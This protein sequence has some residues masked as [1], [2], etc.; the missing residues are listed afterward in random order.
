[1]IN[2]DKLKQL[3]ENYKKSFSTHWKDEKFKWEAV[4]HFQEHWNI[5][6]ENFG[7]MFK[8][9][10]A[11][12]A[13][14]LTSKMFYP[15]GMI[16]DFAKAND[17]STRQ[18]FRSL[19]NENQD[20]PERI[21]AFRNSAEEIRLKYGADTWQKH[22]Q[23]I[24]AIS[25]YLWLM[26]PDKYYIYKH[27][28]HHCVAKTLESNINLKKR[29]SAQTVI[30]AYK[31]CDEI[32]GAI[33]EDKELL[34]MLHHALDADCYADPSYKT[35]TIDVCYYIQQ[36]TH[37][38]ESWFPT[39]YHPGLT[40]KNWLELLN[41]PS[42]FHDYDLKIMKRMKDYGGQATCKQLSVKYGCHANF[43]NRGSSSLAERIAKKTNC[44][45]MTTDTDNSKWW[46]ILYLGQY[47][48]N[49]Q[50]GGY[51]W[52]LRD[53]LAEALNQVDLS[54][55]PLYENNAT[56]SGLNYW[57]LT[58][59]PNIWSFSDMKVGEEQT[60]T[61]Y[62]EEGNKRKVF[63][64]FLDVRVGDI[65][66]GYEATPKKEIVAIAEITQESNEETI[67]F[68]IKE[69]LTSPIPYAEIIASSE[70]QNMEFLKI[71]YGSLFKLSKGEYDF[72]MDLIRDKNPIIQADP[73]LIKYTKA[74]F[75]KEVY[76]AEE[77]Y[78][79]LTALL[80]YKYNVI[81]QGAPGVGKTFSA[82]RLAYSIMGEIDDSRIELIQFHQNYSYEDFIMGYR[83]DGEGF[84]LTEGIFYRFCHKAAEHPDKPYFFII[85]EINRGNMS[86]IFGELL[87]LIEK[88][89]RNTQSTL[90]Y[91]GMPFFVPKNIR[92]IGMMN[93]ADRSLSL[94]DYALRRRFSFFEIEPGF[95]TQGF[96]AYQNGFSNEIFNKLI[97]Q[98]KLLNKEIEHDNSLGKGFQI[99]HSY[100]C[101]RKEDECTLPW[102]NAIVEFDILPML[103][104][105]WFDEPDKLKEWAEK[106]RSV[107]H[108]AE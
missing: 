106:L 18:I 21:E 99:G 68:K 3:L 58:A 15:R 8:E 85:D 44:P 54:T 55:I 63:Q 5:D 41:D 62:N 6:A 42:V 87:M 1:M 49:K 13:N 65:V 100:F 11:K 31:L 64:N 9:A 32:C 40:V 17:D 84:K 25:T 16:L 104:E 59:K 43:Y 79:D 28:L 35:A 39:H 60:Y 47:T 83:P 53:E 95:N 23:T 81:L 51:K 93:T 52:K 90:A 70:L 73:A 74:D 89:Y 46:P 61:L 101:G 57:W 103:A 38:T 20:L 82:K 37:P 75:L 36:S 14:L 72:I 29:G 67:A 98:I 94:I 105:Y 86:K 26:Y 34:T 88:D 45:V 19:F 78:N 96:M 27:D 33:K 24:N 7:E 108:E 12:T 91:N 10:T 22:F 56:S 76:M 69:E 97:E 50:N 30:A 4:K 77:R 102:M 107:F 66:I 80:E 71:K 2:K 48:E 92:L